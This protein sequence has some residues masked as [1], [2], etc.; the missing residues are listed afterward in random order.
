MLVGPKGDPERRRCA[1]GSPR[2]QSFDM[3]PFVA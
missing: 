3:S 2:A 1:D